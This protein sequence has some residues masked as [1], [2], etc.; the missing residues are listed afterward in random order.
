LK[1]AFLANMSHEIRTPLGAM[2]GFA[3]LLRDPSLSGAQRS[4]YIDILARN[5]ENL[6]VIINDILDLSK[7]EAGHLTL[8]FTETRPE[9]ILEDVISL[10][11]VKAKEKNLSLELFMDSS[12]PL[13]IVSDPTRVRQILMNI[14]G[15]AIKFT[16]YGSVKIRAYGLRYDDGRQGI[17]FEVSDTGIGIPEEQREKIF[18][19]FVQADGS[20]TRRFGGTGLGLALS[21]SLARSLGG[22]VSILR[23]EPGQGSVF[24][25]TISDQPER[26]ETMVPAPRPPQGRA[27]NSGKALDGV[28]VLVV[29]DSPD[30]RHLIWLYLR[31]HGAVVDSAEN[32]VAGVKMALSGQFDVI[33]MDV[34]MPEMDGYTATAN[35]GKPA[36]RLQLLLLPLT[37]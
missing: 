37:P 33:L 13:S 34:Q 2:I 30:N 18:E 32:G 26:R 5:G 12:I 29:D 22:E 15:N 4:N 35:S 11:R 14:V 27:Q 25:V 7:V 19:M 8:E 28:R 6:S 24:N 3:D 21:R 9:Q 23:S 36:I 31:K 1:S 10:L 20:T 17:G 16:P